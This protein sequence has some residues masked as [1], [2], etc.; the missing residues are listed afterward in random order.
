MGMNQPAVSKGL[1]KNIARMNANSVVGLHLLVMTLRVKEL[2]KPIPNWAAISHS[3][4][5]RRTPCSNSAIMTFLSAATE[6][7]FL[8]I[9]FLWGLIW[10]IF[11]PSYAPQRRLWFFYFQFASLLSGK[12]CC[13]SHRKSIFL[14]VL[15]KLWLWFVPAYVY[16]HKFQLALIFS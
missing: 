6:L 13:K 4:Q 12:R 10:K 11:V 2:S 1:G 16:P 3:P 14:E 5:P 7:R 15:F 9:S 8:K